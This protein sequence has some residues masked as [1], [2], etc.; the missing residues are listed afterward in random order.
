MAMKFS[1]QHERDEA[2]LLRK[3]HVHSWIGLA[4]CWLPV[5]GL[6]FA[7]GGF[8]RCKV[9]LTR[10]HRRRRAACLAFASVALA[11]AIAAN[12]AG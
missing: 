1:K 3:G 7:A 8:F 11:V 4:L 5:V 6:L 12:R 9:R 2:R 10:K